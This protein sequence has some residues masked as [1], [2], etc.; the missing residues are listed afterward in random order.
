M[1]FPEVPD[2]TRPTVMA[3][4]AAGADRF[5]GRGVVFAEKVVV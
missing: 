3:G 1:K 5:G 2:L 4:V